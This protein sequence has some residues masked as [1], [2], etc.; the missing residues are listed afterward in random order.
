MSTFYLLHDKNIKPNG[1]DDFIYL[2]SLPFKYSFP[3]KFKIDD[4]ECCAHELSNE[5]RWEWNDDNVH[6]LGHENGIK[7]KFI[8]ISNFE[9][10]ECWI[11]EKFKK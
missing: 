6:F 5:F 8:R 7:G 9:S 3:G 1:L 2:I 10:F 11:N 4:I